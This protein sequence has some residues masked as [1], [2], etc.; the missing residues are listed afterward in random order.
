MCVSLWILYYDKHDVTTRDQGLGVTVKG[1]TGRDVI[2][3]NLG[4]FHISRYARRESNTA[5]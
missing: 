1:H 4:Q 5:N 3:A 2:K